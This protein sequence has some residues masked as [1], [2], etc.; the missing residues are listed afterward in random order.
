[1][2]DSYAVIARH[3]AKTLPDSLAERKALLRA[4]SHVL[5]ANHPAATDVAAQLAHIT[6][7]EKLQAEFPL[8]FRD[9]AREPAPGG[10]GHH[11]S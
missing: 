10:D 11:N 2:T 6:A 8:R 5:S 4:L 9:T 1:M 7:L 3:V